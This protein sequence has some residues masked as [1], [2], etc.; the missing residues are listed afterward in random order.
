MLNCLPTR[1]SAYLMLSIQQL[2]GTHAAKKDISDI[3]QLQDLAVR[4]IAGI[5]K[6]DDVENAKT[7]L[8]LIT[9]HKKGKTSG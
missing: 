5:K 1:L 6:R 9:L 7:R 8:E 3:E 4:F 2:L